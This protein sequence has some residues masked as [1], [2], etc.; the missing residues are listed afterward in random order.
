MMHPRYVAWVWMGICTP[1]CPPT[2]IVNWSPVGLCRTCCALRSLLPVPWS[3][4]T[5]IDL[6]GFSF[7]S[8]S[9]KIWKKH[10]WHEA[11]HEI[12]HGCKTCRQCDNHRHKWKGAHGSSWAKGASGALAT[13]MSSSC[14]IKRGPPYILVSIL[15]A[16]G[17]ER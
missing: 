4:M 7:K 16:Q 17:S 3:A 12:H 8:N 10:L 5:A 15:Y 6:L 13:S 1:F 9:C 2:G 11:R 14:S